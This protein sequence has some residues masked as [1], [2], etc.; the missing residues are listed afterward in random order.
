MNNEKVIREAFEEFL[1]ANGFESG[2][3]VENSLVARAFK[4]G[5]ESGQ[6]TKGDK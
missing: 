4:A 2:Y 6:K 1:K 3:Y 5:F